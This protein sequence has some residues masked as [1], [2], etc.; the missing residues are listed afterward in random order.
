[1]KNNVNDMNG[2]RNLFFVTKPHY[3]TPTLNLKSLQITHEKTDLFTINLQ[4][5]N[6]IYKL[7]NLT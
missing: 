1:M 5:R 6:T 2:I 7:H 4:I 3:H